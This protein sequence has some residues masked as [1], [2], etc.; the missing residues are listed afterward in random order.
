MLSMQDTYPLLTWVHG[1]EKRGILDW[2]Q[3]KN[4]ERFACAKI[5]AVARQ[6]YL[7]AS[8]RKVDRRALLKSRWDAE[9]DKRQVSIIYREK[10][11]TTKTP[12]S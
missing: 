10:N 9:L 8:R 3:T 5:V 11:K 4:R 2:L 7:H 1:T 6:T 12:F